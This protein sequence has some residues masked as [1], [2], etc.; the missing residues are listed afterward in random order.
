MNFKIVI[1]VVAAILLLLVGGFAGVLPGL[2][3][4][5]NGTSTINYN[6]HEIIGVNGHE[7]FDAKGYILS[8][9]DDGFSEKFVVSGKI[10]R[11]DWAMSYVKEYRYKVYLKKNVW[12]PYELKSSPDSTS[13]DF[14]AM[15]PGEIPSNWP[16]GEGAGQIYDIAPYTFQLIGD[17]YSDGAIK[18]EVQVLIR[19][20]QFLSSYSWRTL[21]VDEAYLFHGY[22]GL[23][24]PE[25]IDDGVQRPYD[26][27]EIGQ[28]VKIGVETAHGGHSSD[29]KNWRVTLNAPYSGDIESLYDEDS[30]NG[31]AP[32]VE[33]TFYDDSDPANTFFIFTVTPE[34]AET[35]M[36]T[37]VP[38]TVRIWNALI[39][40]GTLY[41]DFI[42][43]IKLAPGDVEF[44]GGDNQVKVG[45][46][47]TLSFSADVNSETQEPIDYFRVSVIYGTN[48]VLLPTNPSSNNWL[49]YTTNV[50]A[51]NNGATI[52]FTPEHESFITAHVKAFD[53]AG[54]PGPRTKT[55]TVWAYLENPAPDDTIDDETGEGYYG[56]G[57]TDP[58]YPWDPGGG[59]WPTPGSETYAQLVAALAA[60]IVFILF[61]IIAV[62]PQIPK[63]FGVWGKLFVVIVGAI[64]AAITYFFVYGVL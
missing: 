40:K 36:N 57:H 31:P 34:M 11:S 43:F 2:G 5:D 24:L 44:G 38:F 46:P 27:F 59:N 4:L 35:S 20:D 45:T 6:A 19:P 14:T 62:L 49:I 55:W 1:V 32:L 9:K 33:Q 60:I 23:W 15:N 41:V 18:V 16:S 54:R 58:W 56:G 25:G 3:L 61:L 7:V 63:P 26:T 21:Q 29:N 48:D 52:T 50:E 22:G 47:Y 39:P 28:E 8:Y 30:Y 42:D 13:M 12:S 37:D 17:E 53:T 64:I 10:K 51:T